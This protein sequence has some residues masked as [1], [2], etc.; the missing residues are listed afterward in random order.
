LADQENKKSKGAFSDLR[1][2]VSRKYVFPD[3][4]RAM[5]AAGGFLCLGILVYYLIDLFFLKSSFTA[6]GPLSSF[7]AKFEKDC[8][9]CHE[10]FDAATSAKCSVCHEKTQTD[11]SA[12]DRLGVYSFA[13]HYVYRSGEAQ[14]IKTAEKNFS[15]KE[16]ACAVCHQEHQGREARITEVPDSYCTQ[17][18]AYSSFNKNHPQFQFI[19]KKIADD[20]TLAFTHI[21]HVKEVVKREKLTDIEKACLYCHNP[22]PDGRHFEPIEFD[23]HCNACH[24]TGNV[25]TPALKIKNADNWMEPGVETLEM[26][27]NQRRPGA[28]WAFNTNPNEFQI[29]PGNRLVKSPVRHEDAWV[30]ENLKMIQRRIHPNLGF[31]ELLKTA[32]EIS[33]HNKK[34]AAA[35]IY[36]EAIQT[37]QNYATGLRGRPEPEVQKDLVKIDSLLKVARNKLR[38]QQIL[39][40]ET[41]FVWPSA[42]VKSSLNP[43]QIAGLADL[44]ASLTERCRECHM[45]EKASILRVQKDQQVLQ[46]AEFNHRAHIVQR[47]CLECHTAIPIIAPADSAK[48]AKASQDRAAIQNIPGI[49]NCRACHNSNETSN[50]CV[51]CHYFHSNK[52]NRASMLLYLD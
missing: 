5:M 6:S 51:T 48:T 42:N 11:L 34:A 22:Q 12:G 44:A 18:H 1:L 24:L 47:R 10:P 39:S 20:S 15:A 21:R 8:A 25:A 23:T 16:E 29:K 26:I 35:V 3:P 28:A 9:S 31:A 36:Q 7:H 40:S 49:E 2:S 32:G 33:P 4:R 37:L 13:S 19:A 52:T 50:R 27:R 38:R 45:V 43:E 17:C 46:R 30:L 14:R 41:K